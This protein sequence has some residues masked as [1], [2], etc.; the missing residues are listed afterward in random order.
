MKC[1]KQQAFS[2]LELILVVFLSSIL[3]IFTFT[4]TKELYETQ[5]INEKLAILKIDLNSTKIIIEKN[6]ENIE[7]KLTYID[8]TLFYENKILLQNVTSFEMSKNS[9]V[10]TIN[11]TLEEKLSQTWKFIL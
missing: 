9:N 8:F 6:L 7:S 4:F 10:L 3:L 11:I 1:N 2:L 5:V